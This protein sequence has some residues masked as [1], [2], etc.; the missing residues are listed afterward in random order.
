MSQ[1]TRR[2][3]FGGREVHASSPPGRDSD[4]EA[5]P[6]KVPGM[7]TVTEQTDVGDLDIREEGLS[8][9]RLATDIQDV[10]VPETLREIVQDDGVLG[11]RPLFT[12][13]WIYHT[14]GELITLPCVDDAYVDTAQEA[15]FLAGVYITLVDDL[16]EKHNDEQTFWELSK[17]MYPAQSPDWDRTDINRNYARSAKRVWKEL[18]RRLETAPRYEKFRETFLFD[19]RT[20]IQSMDFARV[21]AESSGLANR[22]ETWFYETPAIGQLPV[23]DIDLMFSPSFDED[24]LGGLRELAH[25]LQHM[26]RLGNWIITWKREVHEGDFTAGI[27]VEAV[28][29]E[30]VTEHQLDAV[31]EEELDPKVVVDTI[32]S[33]GLIDQF[34]ADWKRRRDTLRSEDLGLSSVDKDEVIDGIERLMQSHL[35]REA[36]E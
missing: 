13:K 5:G 16:A 24:E 14:C 20:A 25:E 6:I 32:D 23:V 30:I 15:K 2:T 36:Y 31:R 33:S 3:R 10:S 1:D 11:D 21:S 22:A 7:T 12:W 18:Q 8:G 26:W 29:Q 9:E 35:A 17:V 4:D 28:E 19:F 34:V 27:F